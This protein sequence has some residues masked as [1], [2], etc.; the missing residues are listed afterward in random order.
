MRGAD[1]IV[2]AESA[3]YVLTS[4]DEG[5][6]MRVAIRF[7]DGGGH[8]EGPL[9]ST[10]TMVIAAANIAPTLD[11]YIT[12]TRSNEAK[13]LPASV[14]TSLAAD[15]D[16]QPLS[17]ILVAPPLVGTLDLLPSGS[18][19]YTPPVDFVGRVTFQ[20]KAT[21]GDLDSNVATVTIDVIPTIPI[22]VLPPSTPSDGVG[23]KD[24]VS[25]DKSDSSSRQA[26]EDVKETGTD[27]AT[28]TSGQ[29]D[30]SARA[31][32]LPGS[33]RESST[34]QTLSDEATQVAI[35]A[36]LASKN[37]SA[38]VISPIG[39]SE[40]LIAQLSDSFVQRTERASRELTDDLDGT[41]GFIDDSQTRSLVMADYALMTRPG[42]MW[43]QLDNYQQNINSRIQG[44]LIVVGSAG[45]AA[46]SFTVGIVA[47]AMRSGFLVSGL[48]AHMPAWSGV[49]P[50]L[51]MQGV[52]GGSA[53]GSAGNET[54]EQLMDRQNKQVE[55][56]EE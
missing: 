4:A 45:A 1:I 16:G 32:L 24:A 49:D 15:A 42:E 26:N 38:S 44:D 8:T 23:N 47:W 36:E 35:V 29:T 31:A 34:G 46:S 2:G 9:V 6:V 27:D 52:T 22:A 54:L 48:I 33:N 56:V 13:V 10:P 41:S 5:R 18:F 30:D 25:N 37:S 11:D 20:W 19:T 40:T 3:V 43:E 53:A 12:S 28:E 55:G 14:F 17:A 50:L 51:I 39:T 21:D 7:E